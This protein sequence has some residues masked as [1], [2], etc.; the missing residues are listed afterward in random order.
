M[1]VLLLKN[2][3]KK[4]LNRN[5]RGGTK[6]RN[7]FLKCDRASEGFLKTI[8]LCEA[9]N[10]L[11]YIL[12]V[13]LLD[14]N[15]HKF[16]NGQVTEMWLETPRRRDSKEKVNDSLWKSMKVDIWKAYAVDH[17]VFSLCGVW[18]HTHDTVESYLEIT[19]TLFTKMYFRSKWEKNNTT[20]KKI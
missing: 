3:L 10:N 18:A 6:E 16:I 14:I 5:K 20:G 15:T 7:N 11:K 9:Y 13:P 19:D 12:K 4:F 1:D 8:D 17:E 2:N